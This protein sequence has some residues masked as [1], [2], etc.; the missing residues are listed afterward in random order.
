MGLMFQY[1]L[2]FGIKLFRYD[3]YDISTCIIFGLFTTNTPFIDS[4][5]YFL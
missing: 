4:L 2:L 1:D 3:I 5:T